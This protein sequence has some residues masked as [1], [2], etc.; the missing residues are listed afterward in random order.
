[1]IEPWIQAG[2][3]LAPLHSPVQRSHSVVVVEVPAL[4]VTYIAVD[5]RAILHWGSQAGSNLERY[6]RQS[7][8]ERWALM[9]SGATALES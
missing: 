5:S 7:L 9:K 3:N 6:S 2:A 1:M 8:D 4:S